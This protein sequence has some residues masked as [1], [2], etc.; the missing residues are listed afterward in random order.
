MQGNTILS[1]LQIILY[2]TLQQAMG[3][4]S[5][6]DFGLGTFGIQVSKVYLFKQL[7]ILKEVQYSRANLITHYIPRTPEEITTETVCTFWAK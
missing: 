4:R 5:P 2:Y 6:R 3:L 7:P 1:L